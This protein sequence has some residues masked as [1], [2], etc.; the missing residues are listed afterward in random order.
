M[1]STVPYSSTMSRPKTQNVWHVFDQISNLID[2]HEYNFRLGSVDTT[3][4]QIISMNH[5]TM[6][7]EN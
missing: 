4:W 5:S 3:F 7:E 1:Y 2:E 6:V